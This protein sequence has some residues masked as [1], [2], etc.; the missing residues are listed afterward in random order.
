MSGA[1]LIAWFLLVT[2]VRQRA[3]HLFFAVFCSV[4]AARWL[5]TA[6]ADWSQPD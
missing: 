2:D 6:I 1:A 3:F 5:I 4:L